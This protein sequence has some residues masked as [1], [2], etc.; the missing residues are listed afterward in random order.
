MFS[1]FRQS[2]DHGVDE[3][4][5]ARSIIPK[6]KSCLVIDDSPYILNLFRTIIKPLRVEARYAEHER[7]GLDMVPEYAPGLI[8]LDIRL[9]EADC[10]DVMKELARMRYRGVIQLMSGRYKDF[11]DQVAETGTRMGL[12]MRPPLQKPFT[13]A[14]I[15]NIIREERL[16]AEMLSTKP[17]PFSLAWKEGWLEVWYQPQIDMLTRTVYGAEALVRARHPVYGPSAPSGCACVTRGSTSR[18][19]SMRRQTCSKIPRSGWP[20]TDQRH[21]MSIF[22][23]SRSSS[24][25]KNCFVTSRRPTV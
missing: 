19:R 5:C 13:P 12:H 25:Q 11:L 16:V 3:K 24:K 4:D 6:G 22:P 10:I 18:F 21:A 14:Q 15:R 8:F 17:F 2:H 20:W 9:K 7:I 1:F 23:A